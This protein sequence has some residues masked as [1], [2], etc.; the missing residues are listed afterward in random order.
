[1]TT[2]LFH[3]DI[4]FSPEQFRKHRRL[5]ALQWAHP[6]DD[7]ELEM[8]ILTLARRCAMHEEDEVPSWLRWCDQV[9][10]AAA[11]DEKAWRHRAAKRG[12]PAF[13]AGDSKQRLEDMKAR[14]DLLQLV[15]S[16]VN[17]RPRGNSYWGRCPFHADK[18][19]SFEVSPEKGLFHCF[20]CGVGGDVI[21]W[22][23]MTETA[24]GDFK[25][26]L[27][28]INDRFP[29]PDTRKLKLAIKI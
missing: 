23:E 2:S 1:M 28:W 7:T 10:L 11:Q 13:N 14:L 12:A 17:L 18:T 8:Y 27:A 5:V 29:P 19:P 16:Q 21:R 3:G 9:D 22:I 24:E 15:S 25:A 4:P 26:A 6:L 20:G